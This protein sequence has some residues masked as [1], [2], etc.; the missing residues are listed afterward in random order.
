MILEIA[1]PNYSPRNIARAAAW[2]WLTSVINAQGGQISFDCAVATMTDATL[3]NYMPIPRGPRGYI[4]RRIQCGQL[5][6]TS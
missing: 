2:S 6:V 5:R 1:K 3:I 4:L